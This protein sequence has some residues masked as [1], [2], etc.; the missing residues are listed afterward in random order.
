MIRASANLQMFFFNL[1]FDFPATSAQLV[2]N[3]G[4][5]HDYLVDTLL[6]YYLRFLFLN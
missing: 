3:K 2:I 1:Q 4:L 5:I 6:T